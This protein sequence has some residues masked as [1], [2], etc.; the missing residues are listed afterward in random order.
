MKKAV[1]LLFLIG[2]FS[3]S[4][5]QETTQPIVASIT[6]SVYASGILKSKDQYQV[7]ANVNGII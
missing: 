3:C 7:F 1:I 2:L 6:E 4:K 5:K